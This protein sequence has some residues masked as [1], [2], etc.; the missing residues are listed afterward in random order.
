MSN[1]N[2]IVKINSVETGTFSSQK[3]RISFIIPETDDVVDLSKS[4][5]NVNMSLNGD[6]TNISAS[7]VSFTDNGAVT[8]SVHTSMLVK[9]VSVDCAKKGL[10]ESIRRADIYSSTKKQYEEDDED[11]I[12]K[13]YL[14]LNA[15][16]SKHK[17]A[18]TPFRELNTDQ[19]SRELD[20]DVRIPLKDILGLGAVPQYDLSKFGRT[21][22]SCEMNFDKLASDFSLGAGD[23][24]WS[25]NTNELS[26]MTNTATNTSGADQDEAVL[27][28]TKTYETEE[29]RDESPFWVGQQLSVTRTDKN[30]TATV[31]VRL[32]AVSYNS[33]NKKLYLTTTPAFGTAANGANVSTISVVGKNPATN[34]LVINSAELVIEYNADKDAPSQVSIMTATTEEDN[35]SNRTTLNKQYAIEPEAMGLVVTLPQPNSIYSN[36]TYLSYRVSVNNEPLTNRDVERESPL[37]YDR[38]ARYMKNKGQAL[39]CLRERQLNKTLIPKTSENNSVRYDT[40]NNA[41]LETLPITDGMKNLGL[42]INSQ[43]GHEINDIV[44]FKEMIKSL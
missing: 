18:L 11:K 25:D 36:K 4:Y 5:I 22:I 28:T 34:D 7:N 6:G 3:N 31:D 33:G 38:K 41:I 40:L 1:L 27:I 19:A 13:N 20:H 10:L 39:G 9:N 8:H 42:E 17:F 37:D 23:V 30:G 14:G 32:T 44:I 2:E 12:D 29:W 43:G 35:G 16:K 21:K 15:P 24:A 26:S